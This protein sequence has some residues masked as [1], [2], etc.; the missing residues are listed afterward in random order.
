MYNEGLGI[1]WYDYKH[2][3]LIRSKLLP[4]SV[5]VTPSPVAREAGRDFV[6]LDM[7]LRTRY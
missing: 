5:P 1:D 2:L 6:A 3:A 7:W 4:L